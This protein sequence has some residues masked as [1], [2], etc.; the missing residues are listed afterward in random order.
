MKK[1]ELKQE[2]ETLRNKLFL[3][4]KKLNEYKQK[5]N[6][7]KLLKIFTNLKEEFGFSINHKATMSRGSDFKR[8]TDTY[9]ITRDKIEVNL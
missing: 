8:I 3:A 5:E 9:E 4:E 1:E 7:E 2:N 6:D